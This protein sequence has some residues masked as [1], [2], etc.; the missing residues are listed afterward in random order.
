[1]PV[2]NS[3]T[4][5]MKYFIRVFS[6]GGVFRGVCREDQSAAK[7]LRFAPKEGEAPRKAGV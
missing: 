1:M 6:F 7:S 5:A 2:A 3:A 4:N